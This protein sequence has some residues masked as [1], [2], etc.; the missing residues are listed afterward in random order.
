MRSHHT[1][2]HSLSLSYHFPSLSAAVEWINTRHSALFTAPPYVLGFKHTLV[3]L[4]PIAFLSLN[5]RADIPSVIHR[6][7]PIEKGRSSLENTSSRGLSSNRWL[8]VELKL[9]PAQLGVCEW[10]AFGGSIHDERKSGSESPLES[11]LL[12]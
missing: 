9:K 12:T 7:M 11:P 2:T 5:L 6:A 1:H 8:N 3:L 10:R 4:G